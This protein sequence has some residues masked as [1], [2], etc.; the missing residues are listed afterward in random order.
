MDFLKK[1][2]AIIVCIGGWLITLGLYSGKITQHDKD[3]MSLQ[4]KQTSQQVVLQNIS[5]SLAS[6]NT[7]VD[8]LIDDKIKK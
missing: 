6:L 8:L 4:E 5:S 7:K 2:W 1:Y 3:I